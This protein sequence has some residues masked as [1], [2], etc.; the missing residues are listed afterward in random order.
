MSNGLPPKSRLGQFGVEKLAEAEGP[1]VWVNFLF[2]FLFLILIGVS[3]R[4]SPTVTQR[5]EW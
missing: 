5:E 1:G 3:F 2:L 4:L